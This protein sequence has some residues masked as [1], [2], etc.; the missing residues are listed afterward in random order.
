MTGDKNANPREP[1]RVSTFITAVDYLFLIFLNLAATPILIR[2]LGV[3]GYG[4][5]VF[6]SIF[7]IRGALNF[8]DLGME[9]SLMNFIPRMITDGD[10]RRLQ[11]TLTISIIYYA[12]L[13]AILSVLLY[14]FGG[15]ITT[16][17]L[18]DDTGLSRP[19]I[20]RSLS[21]I[22]VMVFIQFLTIPFTA[23]LQGMQRFVLSK[24]TSI[25]M[26]VIRYA[27]L[28]AAAVLY[29]RLDVAFLVILATSALH[30][31]ILLAIFRFALPSYRRM[32]L[33]IDGSLVREL[34]NYTSILFASR[35]I[36]LIH[37]QL[38]KVLIWLYL[39]V[40]SMTIYDVIAR[41]YNMLRLVLTVINAAIIPEVA[42]LHKDGD[43]AAVKRRFLDSVRHANLVLMPVLAVLYVYI[44]EMLHLWVGNAYVPYAGLAVILFS[45]YLI[46]P[47]ASVA[48]TV[49]VGLELVAQ[50]IW[51]PIVSTVI[52]VVVSLVLLHQIGLAGLLIGTLCAELFA[53]FPY[54]IT[55]RRRLGFAVREILTPML[56]IGAVAAICAAGQLAVRLLF[57]GF[58]P[59]IV[60]VGGAIFC[61]N[62]LA[63]YRYFLTDEEKSHLRAI[64][65][66]RR[67]GKAA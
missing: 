3:E 16:Q 36:G 14:L 22:S 37:R 40:S 8:F 63:N 29:R 56:L 64:I 20:L 54:L 5:F 34:L 21:I 27:L 61:L 39:T 44:G 6:L 67:G 53:F 47:V 4:A 28:V 30:L 62:C 51:I 65:G 2:H 9:G 60:V 50:T 38:D 32:R 33:R 11:D 35:V 66:R 55:M 48:S 57:S 10:D 19:N 13:G 15:F 26:N 17:L 52:N 23:I 24:S 1:V 7:S 59:V 49:V 42:R 43:M 58:K 41:P 45:V 31:V 18:H 46:L 12:V 25:V